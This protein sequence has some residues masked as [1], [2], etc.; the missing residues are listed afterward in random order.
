MKAPEFTIR[1]HYCDAM[2]C[3]FVD[4]EPGDRINTWNVHQW[5]HDNGIKAGDWIHQ[6]S[7]E[8]LS[9]RDTIAYAG[10][11]SQTDALLFYLRFR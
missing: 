11:F 6:Q 5:C 2:E 9:G 1:M 8:S 7:G 3:W 4:A 10:F